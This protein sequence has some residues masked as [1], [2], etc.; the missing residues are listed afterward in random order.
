MPTPRVEPTTGHWTSADVVALA[1][2]QNYAAGEL[3]RLQTRSEKWIAGLAAIVGVLTTAVVIKGPETFTKL[4]DQRELWGQTFNPKEWVVGLMA[5]GGLLIGTGIVKAYGAAYGDPFR[6]DELRDRAKQQNI[7]GAYDDWTTAVNTAAD[8][9]R[10]SLKWAVRFTVGGVLLLGAAVLLTWTTPEA[11]ASET[12][13]CIAGEAGAVEII[14]AIPV[15]KSGSLTIVP[16][17]D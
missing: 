9:A 1:E 15:V 16:C 11:K 14:G 5:V 2:L 17:A 10:D 4:S 8:D 13:I 3:K 7:E 6:T 12:T